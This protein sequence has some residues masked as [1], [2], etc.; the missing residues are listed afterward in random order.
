MSIKRKNTINS[1]TVQFLSIFLIVVLVIVASLLLFMSVNQSDAIN[2]IW[3][4]F[5]T[6]SLIVVGYVFGNSKK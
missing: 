2:D 3:S 5:K 1:N 4:H 6:I